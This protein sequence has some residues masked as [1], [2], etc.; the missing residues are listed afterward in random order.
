MPLDKRTIGPRFQRIWLTDFERIDELFVGQ[1]AKF[2]KLWLA[3][4][5]VRMQRLQRR[6]FYFRHP[7]AR[8]PKTFGTRK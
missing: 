5:T 7:S 6:L 3:K 1:F 4:R 8:Q 2:L